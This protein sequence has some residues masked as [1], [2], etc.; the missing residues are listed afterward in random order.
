MRETT[1]HD[2]ALERAYTYCTGIVKSK[3]R[4]FYF[5]SRCL[6]RPIRR[7][8]YALYA[9]CRTLD[10][11][12]DIPPAGASTDTI[13]AQLDGWRRWLLAGTPSCSDDPVKYALAHVARTSELPLPPLLDLLDGLRDDVAPRHLL[14]A[15]ALDRYCYCVAGTV[16][17]VM[18]HLLGARDASAAR[19]ACDLGIAMQLTNVLRDVGEDLTRGRIYL[20]ADDMARHGYR[21]ADLEQGIVDERFVALMRQYI[22]RARSFYASGLAGLELLPRD[23]QFAIGLA[24]H[25]YAAI[26]AK[27]EHTGFD[28]LTQRTHTG[29]RD[30]LLLATRL[31]LGHTIPSRGARS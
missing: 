6:P 16:G 10:D 7:P 29:R 3:A 27:I 13:L 25:T 31:Y 18:A 22:A 5:A 12:A 23:S 20:P 8:V 1:Q 17:I 19:H 21:R 24:A 15:T 28:V 9:F 4:S 2:A 11:L 26:L 30:K 14:D